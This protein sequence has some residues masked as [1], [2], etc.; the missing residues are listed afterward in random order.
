METTKQFY[1]RAKAAAGAKS[2]YEFARTLGLTRAAVSKYVTGKSS[3]DD[4]VAESIA[5]ILGLEPGYVMACAH[6]ERSKDTKN[7]ARWL[8]V[9]ALLA[10]VGLPPAHGGQLDNNGPKPAKNN[11]QTDNYAKWR[12]ALAVFLFGDWLRLA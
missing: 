1:E 10:A 2:D 8:H 11:V 9:A 7:R 4:G 3:F 12:D 6:A 5:K